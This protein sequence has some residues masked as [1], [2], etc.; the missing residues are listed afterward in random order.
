MA[1]LKTSLGGSFDD[2]HYKTYFIVNGPALGLGTLNL[3]YFSFPCCTVV[4]H[5]SCLVLFFGF[6]AFEVVGVSY[7]YFFL[8]SKFNFKY[9]N[10][11]FMDLEEISF[12]MGSP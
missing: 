7:F 5:Y 4:G 6:F 3:V 10:D 8:I 2:M 11:F 9:C 12:L 1:S